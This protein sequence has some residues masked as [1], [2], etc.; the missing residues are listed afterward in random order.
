[1]IWGKSGFIRKQETAFAKKCLIWKS[2]KEGVPLPEDRVLPNHA[3]AVVAQAHAMAK[4][5]GNN[6]LDVLKSLVK[7]LKAL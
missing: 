6:V 1:M 3:R 4:Q 5:S 2:E 7:D